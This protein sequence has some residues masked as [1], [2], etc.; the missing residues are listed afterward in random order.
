MYVH[1]LYKVHVCFRILSSKEV[2]STDEE[3][4]SGA[5][6]SDDELGKNLE[7]MLHGKSSHQ[8]LSHEQEEME[9]EE[10]KKLLSEDKKVK[11]FYY[12]LYALYVINSAG[13]L[14][15]GIPCH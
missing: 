9:R 10:L 8:Q 1:N 13:F 12:N 6:E 3:S 7:N 4:S 2:L 11:H 5:G 14:S 15:C